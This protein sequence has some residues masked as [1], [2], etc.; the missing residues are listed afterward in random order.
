MAYSEM[1]PKI[2][3]METSDLAQYSF[4]NNLIVCLKMNILNKHRCRV[5]Q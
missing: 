5:I 2:H 1:L 4:S 3:K